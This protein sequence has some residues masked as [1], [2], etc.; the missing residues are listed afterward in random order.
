MGFYPVSHGGTNRAQIFPKILSETV[1]ES[2]DLP[3]RAQREIFC[4]GKDSERGRSLPT[5]G[6]TR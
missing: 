6:M 3:F 1:K 2:I 5:V 4:L